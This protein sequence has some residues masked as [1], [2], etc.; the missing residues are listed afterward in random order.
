MNNFMLSRIHGLI[1]TDRNHEFMRD[2]SPP[3]FQNSNPINRIQSGRMRRLE[4]LALISQ[5]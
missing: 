5:N 3:N 1:E 4:D 2:L